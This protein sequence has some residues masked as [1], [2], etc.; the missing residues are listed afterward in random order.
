M[1]S[2]R[3]K[4]VS[5]LITKGTTPTTVGGNFTEYGIN[6][7]KSESISGSKY[8]R[9]ELY[10]FIDEATDE[11][12]KRSRLAEFDLLFSIAGAY[13][14]KIAIVRKLDLPANTNQA[15]GIVR[16]DRSKVNVDYVYYYFS[17]K[18]INNYINNLSSQSSQPNLN[19]ELLGNLEF[20]LL[21]L[22]EQKKIADVLSAFDAKI[23][24]NNKINAE[25]EGLAKLVYDYWFVQFDFPNGDGKP[26]RQSGGKMRYDA[27]L[28]R[29][30]PEG[31][32]VKSLWDIAKYYNGL[33]MQK[34]RPTDENRLRVIKIKEMGEGFNENTEFAKASLPK[35]AIVEDGDVLF[36]WSATLEVMIWAG[37]KG[38]LNQHI[39]KVTSQ[40]YPK[41]FFF[42]ALRGYLAH[43][44]MMAEK[45]KTTMGH[46]TLEHL[47]QSR[48]VVPPKEIIYKL[49][50]ILTPILNKQVLLKQENLHLSEL[51]DWLLPLLMNGQVGVG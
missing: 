27:V 5:S 8:L 39:F 32:E 14:G 33:A 45:R 31:W 46:I 30:V 12:L 26:Y 47:K 20:N 42:F 11:K 29:E 48:I 41:S 15:V 28:G 49:D 22:T 24:L 43:F 44:K 18:H 21:E 13:L 1:N 6:F 9:N 37:G 17:Q 25:L 4:D 51:R 50:K 35:D 38:A 3:L 36:S 10:Q 2:A 40:N 19:L 7:I 23:E 34:H 16:L